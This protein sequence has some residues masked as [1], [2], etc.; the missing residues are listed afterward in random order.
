MVRGNNSKR[1]RKLLYEKGGAKKVYHVNYTPPIGIIGEDGMPRGCMFGVD[2][3][4]DDNFIA[5][6]RTQEEINNEMRMPVVYISREGMFKVYKKLGI[7][8]QN[9]CTYCIGGKHPFDN[10]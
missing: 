1:E 3:P 10:V 5:R 8:E 9:L 7:S 2:M 4:P 6:G